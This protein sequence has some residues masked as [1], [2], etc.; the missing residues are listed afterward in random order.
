MQFIVFWQEVVTHI[1]PLLLNEEKYRY[2]L[3][4]L[5]SGYYWSCDS[6]KCGEYLHSYINLGI[7]LIDLDEFAIS[8]A[9]FSYI[10]ESNGAHSGQG[11]RHLHSMGMLWMLALSPLEVMRVAQWVILHKWRSDL[12]TLRRRRITIVPSH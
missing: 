10:I 4:T 1:F 6:S 12:E 2:V 5:F 8:I 7:T 3:L 11:V 9:I